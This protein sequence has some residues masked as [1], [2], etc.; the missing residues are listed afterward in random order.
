MKSSGRDPA[1][2]SR[3]MAAVRS[4]DSKAELALR[5]VLHSEGIRYRLHAKHVLGRP[6]LCIVKYKL[7]VFVDGDL[8]H[9]NAMKLRHL[10]RPEELFPSRTDWWTA[11]IQRNVQR[12]ADV[13]ERLKRAGWVVVRV[14]E[15]EVLT[16]P[17]AAAQHV[18]DAL[19]QRKA[20]LLFNRRNLPAL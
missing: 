10:S 16:S 4:K 20:E 14:W 5:Q 13:T 18:R 12:D 9:G 19:N 17:G 8:W 7:A 11:K 2:T 3:M 1:V 15:S 6:D